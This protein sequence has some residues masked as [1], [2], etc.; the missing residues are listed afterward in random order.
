MAANKPRSSGSL[1]PPFQKLFHHYACTV[2]AGTYRAV[3]F[4]VYT[5]QQSKGVSL[6]CRMLRGTELN[7][8]ALYGGTACYPLLVYSSCILQR[9]ITGLVRCS[10]AYTWLR[11]IPPL[12]GVHYTVRS[13][14]SGTTA[15]GSARYSAQQCCTVLYTRSASTAEVHEGLPQLCRTINNGM[16]SPPKTLELNNR[17]C[18]EH[19][20]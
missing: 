2:M 16:P 11:T 10:H 13:R 1:A 19:N 6:Y 15:S 12:C 5:I 18:S 4:F 14:Q 17:I 7:R 20:S 9:R 8:T 3:L